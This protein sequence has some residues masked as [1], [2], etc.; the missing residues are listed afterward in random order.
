[1]FVL[2]LDGASWKILK[3]MTKEL[4]LKF[5][6]TIFKKGSFGDNKSVIPPI[7]GTA[8]PSIFTG[9]NPGKHG[10]F[11]FITV[12]DD[13]STEYNS[14]FNVKSE[15][16]WET[17]EKNNIKCG[18]INIPFSS[19]FRTKITFGEGDHLTK[20]WVNFSWPKSTTLGIRADNPA[21][22]K[23]F[24]EVLDIQFK[25]IDFVLK[26]K[27]TDFFAI[28]IFINDTITHFRL[29]NKLLIKKYLLKLDKYLMD[30]YD[31]IKDESNLFIISDHGMHETFG[32]FFTN[33]WLENNGFLVF[34][35]KKKYIFSRIFLNKKLFDKLVKI[36]TFMVLKTG[37]IK[38]VGIRIKK[39]FH[40]KIKTQFRDS[41][42]LYPHIV[43]KNIDWKKTKAYGIGSHGVIRINLKGREKNGCVEQK[44]YEKVKNDIIKKLK[45]I[46][47]IEVF[48][49]E[50]IYSG[51]FTKQAP[52]ILFEIED[53]QY[54]SA[55][56]YNLKKKEFT[57]EGPNKIDADHSI[58]GIFCCLGKNIVNKEIKCSILDL[59]PTILH[60]F[61]IP[62]P[63]DMDGRVLTE[64]F[65][66]KRKKLFQKKK[67]FEV[68]ELS[69]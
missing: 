4:E 12:K 38:F 62:I 59:T 51:K 44:D 6:K 35:K 19:P 22:E 29:K 49:R 52:D 39:L 42:F 33:N 18:I 36:I 31:K 57:K 26:N 55:N 25:E 67:I 11:D 8:W 61:N 68:G 7:T 5:F 2:G 69:I 56:S 30:L 66:D 16:L 40:R 34:K 37:L 17:L 60:I 63:K 64:I 50:E 21:F 14:S 48:K 32:W 54:K 58:Y 9:K 1:M 23:R 53:G 3:P 65:K 28:N 13:F 43:A 15:F 41:Q 46:K 47:G 24:F 45:K 27:E 10:V 20:D